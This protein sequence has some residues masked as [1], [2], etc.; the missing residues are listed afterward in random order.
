MEMYAG[1]EGITTNTVP[2]A[3][4]F[5]HNVYSSYESLL[6]FLL[7]CVN[8]VFKSVILCYFFICLSCRRKFF[9][10]LFTVK[11]VIKR[12]ELEVS[13]VRSHHSLRV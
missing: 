11:K 2:I 13:F 1:I 3:S 8:N 10:I 6:Q 4:M 9:N 5:T 12:G 7:K